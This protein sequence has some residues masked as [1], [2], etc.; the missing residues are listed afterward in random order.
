MRP[1][2]TADSTA[3][4][5]GL[6]RLIQQPQRDE[7]LRTHPKPHFMTTNRAATQATIIASD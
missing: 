5:L 6:P 3:A 1:L 4:S 2:A 7:L